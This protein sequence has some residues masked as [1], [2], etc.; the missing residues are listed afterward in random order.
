VICDT[1][2]H[3]GRDSQRSM[4]TAQIVV[5]EMQADS[6]F[7]VRE[8]LAKSVSQPGKPPAHHSDREVLSFDVARAYEP[9]IGPP[10]NHLG[11]T[12]HVP[13][14][15]VTLSDCWKAAVNFY[16]LRVIHGILER[17]IDGRNIRSPTIRGDLRTQAPC[18]GC[19]R[20][21]ATTS[22]QC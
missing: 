2:L 3:G 9:R 10:S 21:P 20:A 8:F 16:K 15:S 14:W 6:G 7:Q 4:N 19:L 18:R 11:Y 12:L 22:T 1:G 17:R 5:G 13:R